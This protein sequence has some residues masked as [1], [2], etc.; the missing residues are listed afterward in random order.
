MGRVR[1]VENSPAVREVAWA[2]QRA[3]TR[4]ESIG[5]HPSSRLFLTVCIIVDNPRERF[6]H[7]D[8]AMRGECTGARLCLGVAPLPGVDLGG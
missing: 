7:H 6:E 4:G 8:V 3:N 1:P 2:T 5:L